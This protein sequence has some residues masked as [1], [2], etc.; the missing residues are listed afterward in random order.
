MSRGEGPAA[1]GALLAQG[2]EEAVLAV[3]DDEVQPAVEVGVEDGDGLAALSVAGGEVDGVASLDEIAWIA[4]VSEDGSDAPLLDSVRAVVRADSVQGMTLIGGV[5]AYANGG[6]DITVGV[7][8][9]GPVWAHPDFGTRLTTDPGSWDDHPTSVAG[10]IAGDGSSSAASGGAAFQ[11]R[12]LAPHARLVS[13]SGWQQKLD[14]GFSDL[15]LHRD[16][17]LSNTS[18]VGD[19]LGRYG[20]LAVAID[21]LARGAAG[22]PH[23]SVLAAGNNGWNPQYPP[24]RGYYSVFPAA[25]NG[26]VVGNMWHNHAHR[27]ETSSMGPTWDGRL[28]PQLMAPADVLTW[29]K[30]GRPVDVDFIRFENA[31]ADVGLG[32][33]FD[34]PSDLAGW[35]VV[36]NASDFTVAAGQLH[37]LSRLVGIVISPDALP[38]PDGYGRIHIRMR[39]GGGPDPI[40]NEATV[41]WGTIPYCNPS[42]N[43]WANAAGSATVPIKADGGW[44]DLKIDTGAQGIRWVRVEPHDGSSK[45]TRTTKRGGGYVD[46]P[47]TSSAAPVVAGATALLMQ[48]LHASTGR[49]PHTRPFLSS[50]LRGLLFDTAVDLVH[51]VP[52]VVDRNNPDTNAPVTYGPGPDFA[53]GF[54]KLDIEAAVAAAKAGRWIEAAVHEWDARV[55]TLEVPT[56]ASRLT[57]TLVWDDP[58]ADPTSAFDARK[59]VHDLDM[60]V[61]LPGQKLALP[62]VPKPPPHESWVSSPSGYDPIQPGDIVDAAPGVDDTNA[63]E[64]IVVPSPPAG[65]ARVEV[66]AHALMSEGPWQTFT[67]VSSAPIAP[68]DACSSPSHERCNGVDDDCN[69]QVDEGL[70]AVPES[71]NAVDDDCDGTIDESCP[72]YFDR[73]CARSTDGCHGSQACL[74]PNGNGHYGACVPYPGCTAGSDAGGPDAG[75][76][77]TGGADVGAVEGGGSDAGG[78]DAAALD[79][80]PADTGFEPVPDAPDESAAKPDGDAQ[81]SDAA[82]EPDAGATGAEASAEGSEAAEATMGSESSEAETSSE[83]EADVVVDALAQDRIEGGADPGSATEPVDDDAAQLGVAAQEAPAGSSA[84]AQGCGCTTAGREPF[85]EMGGWVGLA[86]GIAAA[87][88]T[89]RKRNGAR[90]AVPRR[91]R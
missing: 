61:T 14:T 2:H 42:C 44:E 73:P 45:A 43:V 41:S 57:V 50:T 12:G 1:V 58:A 78:G 88:R 49:D 6:E 55:F 71:C 26:I 66:R 90:E 39:I 25:K 19:K 64:Q 22:R 70:G 34:S 60:S 35:R 16:V 20:T 36:Q 47:A 33:E 85:G 54:G 15:V 13:K 32:L 7:F 48:A 23:T 4:S 83:R 74:D 79:V 38:V 28:V 80:A 63:F 40:K 72:C 91:R 29:P 46:F 24:L 87:V 21:A 3:D 37:L 56:G 51:P 62:L 82:V 76:V 89:A 86:A 81:G 8:D 31:S 9:N 53:T 10:I 67:V 69:G 27:V 17:H 84:R 75:G 52:W 65:K 77:E 18:L 30:D 5:P 59:L 68:A 11:W